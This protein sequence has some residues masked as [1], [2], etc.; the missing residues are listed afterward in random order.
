MAR[1][2]T[3]PKKFTFRNILFG[4]GDA[5]KADFSGITTS[6]QLFITSAL[7]KA[8][9]DVNEEGTEAAA[10][11]AIE[12]GVTSIDPN[13]PPTFVADHPFVFVIQNNETGHILFIGKM[14]NPSE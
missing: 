3:A 12:V 11:T 7:H 6:E 14:N 2:R 1:T 13:P 8:Y 5:N 9:V 10:V 4:F